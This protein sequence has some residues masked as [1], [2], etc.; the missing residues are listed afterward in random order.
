MSDPSECTVC[1]SGPVVLDA[2]Y[3]FCADCGAQQEGRETEQEF[4]AFG[5][6]GRRI[7]KP[8][9]ERDE[10]QKRERVKK[11]RED[12][13]ITE[14]ALPGEDYPFWL[15]QIGTRLC[16]ATKILAKCSFVLINE[17][18]VPE[19]C[20]ENS[21][22]IFY[23]YLRRAGIAFCEEE[24]TDDPDKSFCPLV[25]HR[26]IDV[27]NKLRQNR[28]RATN[29][30]K[31]LEKDR[32]NKKDAWM[33]LTST[34]EALKKVLEE[35]EAEISATLEEVQ[36]IERMKTSL[37][38]DAVNMAAH[39]YLGVDLLLCIL[40][41][42][43]HLSGCKW[44]LLSDIFRW[45]REGRFNISRSQLLALNFSTSWT[46]EDP[47]VK[48]IMS[49]LNADR[50]FHVRNKVTLPYL[51]VQPVSE[52]LRVVSFLTQFI[53]VPRSIQ[54]MDF[55][56][57]LSRFVYN[58]N[59]PIAFLKHLITILSFLPP[60]N[61]DYG[62]ERFSFVQ[63]IDEGVPLPTEV[64]AVALILFALK[65]FFGL[66]DQREFNLKPK[67]QQLIEDEEINEELDY[68][69]FGEWLTQLEMRTHCWQGTSPK[70]VMSNDFHCD[71][72]E[73]SGVQESSLIHLY[74]RPHLGMRIISWNRFNPFR[75]CVPNT[76]RIQS[77]PFVF[78]NLFP[79]Y[80][81]P[82]PSKPLLSTNNTNLS[83]SKEALF[84]PLQY[85]S[86]KNSDIQNE[87]SRVSGIDKNRKKIFFHKF[88]DSSLD[89][90][91]PTTENSSPSTSVEPQEGNLI[92][93]MF[94]CANA[95]KRYPPGPHKNIAVV[96]PDLD[97]RG[98]KTEFHHRDI[99]INS[100]PIA[101][102]LATKSMKSFA[103]LLRHLALSVSETDH[104]LFFVFQ[105]IESMFFERAN[106]NR[107]KN[108]LFQFGRCMFYSQQETLSSRFRYT[109][110]LDKELNNNDDIP[111]YKLSY[112]P[113]NV[114]IA[115]PS[116][117]AGPFTFEHLHQ[118]RKVTISE[119][120]DTDDLESNRNINEI[121]DLLS[122]SSSSSDNDDEIL[123]AVQ[124][125]P[126]VLQEAANLFLDAIVR[127]QEMMRQ[128][129]VR[130]HNHNFLQL[131]D[132][133][134]NSTIQ[135][136]YGRLSNL[137][138]VLC[139]LADSIFNGPPANND[140]FNALE[141]SKT[142]IVG[143]SEDLEGP[144]PSISPSSSTSSAESEQ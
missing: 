15:D 45:Y 140:E 107:I 105:M 37:S 33:D 129:T 20:L 11:I 134:Q 25:R 72:F 141:N 63:P 7:N 71:Q 74:R 83:M 90:E 135:T 111:S 10:L 87:S 96:I 126:A 125:S 26:N 112:K 80:L 73:R 103:K 110:S 50:R 2:G 46:G 137:V 128:N 108:D 17:F 8:K 119:S 27:E 99:R 116:E 1:G 59:L 14:R 53:N 24:T 43:V 51:G 78:E 143:L 106:F 5:Q 21:K 47:H 60:V 44:I 138:Y 57:V 136:L 4:G 139:V 49:N 124:V 54:T 30:R 100:L 97:D 88:Y 101:P 77:Q 133:N 58:L 122:S 31:L 67:H 19:K 18:N 12:P 89:L 76:V 109:I 95:Y 62:S 34:D 94:P 144:S 86:S 48:N 75:G 130:V 55:Q 28:T 66:D 29:L 56:K 121:G 102:L 41:L 93:K 113:Q 82:S 84:T 32:K 39:I 9:K 142:I 91:L 131:P 115:T 104:L 35:E 79:T 36:F 22:F 69:N 6:Q 132:L 114:V 23:S 123:D 52:S 70:I 118:H 127:I 68:F 38:V 64:K 120:E 16:T 61:V 92:L 117:P 98:L 85:Q 40:F 65:L 81:S 13:F 42:S 3:Y